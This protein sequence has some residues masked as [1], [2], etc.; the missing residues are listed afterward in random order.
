MPSSTKKNPD[1]C[2]KR[3]LQQLFDRMNDDEVVDVRKPPDGRRRGQF[4]Q[5]WKSFEAGKQLGD[6]SLNNLTWNN[7]GWRAADATRDCRDV[8]PER[9]YQELADGYAS[10]TWR[11]TDIR[12]APRSFED[13]LLEKYWEERRGQ[14][15]VEAPVGGEHD[16]WT[17]KGGTRRLD[18]LRIDKPKG[19]IVLP[20]DELIRADLENSNGA[21]IEVIEVK[22]ALNR[23]VIGQTQAGRLLL[24]AR[25]E[26]D[27]E[28]VREVV[29]CEQ[30]DAALEWVCAKLGIEVWTPYSAPG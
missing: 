13:H 17:G 12:W 30:R 28:L 10:R 19:K 27:P 14:I 22:R 9:V 11:L 21:A 5:G 18:G 26:F 24:C 23:T 25:Y 6:E 4:K 29:V 7:L 3:A 8:E 2:W 20:D 1:D 16:N 15:Y